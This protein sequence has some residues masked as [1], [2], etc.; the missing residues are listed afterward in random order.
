MQA[1]VEVIGTSHWYK[2]SVFI[3]IDT[4]LRY[5]ALV[6]ASVEGIGTR[7]WYKASV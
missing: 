6:Q 2:A 4:R 3:G 5:K 1:L 7:H